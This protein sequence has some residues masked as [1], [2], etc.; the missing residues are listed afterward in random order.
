MM[1]RGT[2]IGVFLCSERE[3]QTKVS[4]RTFLGKCLNCH[5][6]IYMR[7]PLNGRTLF[8]PSPFL[9]CY[10]KLPGDCANRPTPGF[11]DKSLIKVD[12]LETLGNYDWAK[13]GG[14]VA[15]AT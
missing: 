6:V 12:D 8:S 10:P 11:Q 9:P 3:R 7:M 1:E 13:V 14:E 5:D 2:L 15:V 4:R